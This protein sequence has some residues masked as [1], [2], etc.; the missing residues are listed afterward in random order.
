MKFGRITHLGR[1]EGARH[2]LK[3]ETD[4]RLRANARGVVVSARG[5]IVRVLAGALVVLAGSNVLG[6]NQTVY[7]DPRMVFRVARTPDPLMYPWRMV[8][9][10]TAVDAYGFTSRQ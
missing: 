6:A 7:R 10:P 8:S 4:A 2:A 1:V 3:W 5:P 9:D